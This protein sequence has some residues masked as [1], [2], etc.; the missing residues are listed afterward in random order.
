[1]AKKS[2]HSHLCP[3]L[4][5]NATPSSHWVQNILQ[6]AL[7]LL[8]VSSCLRDIIDLFSRA[9][10]VFVMFLSKEFSKIFN[11]KCQQS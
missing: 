10:R 8:N 4:V 3:T 7:L 5:D 1:M 2:T 9:E 11:L 6:R